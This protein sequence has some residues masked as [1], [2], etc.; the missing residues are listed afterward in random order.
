[1]TT[2]YDVSTEGATFGN[3]DTTTLNGAI[4]TIDTGPV[5][6]YVINITGPLDLTSQLLAI[7]LPAGSTLTIAGTNGSGA[8]QVQPIDGAGAY[9]G[10][11]V[12][13]GNVT[14]ED[15]TIQDAKAIGG[16][17]GSGAEGGGG[18]AGLGGGLFVAAAAAV[19]LNSVDFNSDSATGGAG[20]NALGPSRGGG[21]GLEGGPGGHGANSFS[22][23]GGGIGLQAAGGVYPG[24]NGGT[25]IVPGAGSGAP[26]N[27]AAS[28]SGGASAGGGGAGSATGGG[29]GGQSTSGFLVAG[30]FG[31]GGASAG[32]GG[33]GGG[34]GGGGS[35]GGA[36][37]FGGGGGGGLHATGAAG[38]GAGTGGGADGG[39]G[40]GGG[41]GAGGDI[42]V[43]Q[44]GTIT[45]ESGALS[46]GS[47][48]G[49][50]GGAG[51]GADGVGGQGLGSGIFLQGNG[52]LTFAPTA[53]QTETI[54]D[55]ITDETGS[56]GIGANRGIDF[57]GTGTLVLAAADTYSGG[58][59]V[60]VGTLEFA[61]GGSITG[62]VTFAGAATLLVDAGTNQIGGSINGA[63]DGDDIDLRFQPYATGDHIVWDQAGAD[64]GTLSL[65]AS[66]GTS[67]QTLALTGRYVTQDF[68][69]N[70]D[71]NG[72]TLIDVISA[73]SGLLAA[74]VPNDFN[75]DG[76][77]D[78]LWRESGALA[79]PPP[80]AG[81]RAG[82]ICSS[83]RSP[84]G[85]AID[86]E[87]GSSTGSLAVW[88]M[89]GSSV[90]SSAAPTYQGSVVTPDSSWSV[91]GVAD[92]NGDGDADVLWRQASSSLLTVWLMQGAT[93]ESGNTITFQGAAVKPDASWDVIGIGDFNGDADADIVW[94][95]STTDALVDWS[96]NGSTITSSTNFTYQGNVVA[97]DSTWSVV[98]IGNFAGN[99]DSDI[100]WRQSA[101]DT[102][103]E[104][105]MNGSTIE[106][107]NVVTLQG[108]AVKP[109]ASWSVAGVG[110]FTGNGVSDVLWRQSSTG[111]L[112]MW[113]MDGSSLASVAAVTY[114]GNLVE[115]DSSWNII[116]VGDFNGTANDSGILWR[117]S[118]SG[119]LVEWQMNGSQ[120]VSSQ[121]VGSQGTP[122][123]PNSTWQAQVKPTDFA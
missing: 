83:S 80:P 33:F 4:R 12:Y 102:V 5:D 28:G 44:G 82:E 49:G 15:L 99:G 17:G 58:T 74:P 61:P 73:S 16:A 108:A 38:F 18:G 85:T 21:G 50:A 96:M 37:G 35:A 36:G 3:T 68:V 122:V 9:N 25:G 24:V 118:T 30:G 104:W 42:F 109:D 46:G 40:G 67:L 53:A 60:S 72:G 54:D 94:R 10:F 98:G 69:A 56:G 93:I 1:M 59:T 120:I 8:A 123:P 90:A 51:A 106:S 29:G 103:T 95:Q 62:G 86:D 115:P 79:A 77:S 84:V 48:A 66:D 121:E 113:L 45:I 88:L 32:A 47:A 23:G 19:T 71:H 75:G 41:L 110:N 39:A 92:F 7:D 81:T 31:G 89:N 2:T 22:G 87:A 55:A 100:L 34:G 13:S 14:I 111:V 20:G 101:T 27:G 57:D 117:Q 97:P 43:Q 76:I 63:F 78:L 91:Q 65:D 119:M 64:S 114:Q 107:G 52:T 70:N 26:G 11:F 6:D 116:E 105:Q 112:A